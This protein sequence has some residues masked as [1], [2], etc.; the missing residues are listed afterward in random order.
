MRM[1]TL[2]A[3]LRFKG[4]KGELGNCFRLAVA[5]CLDCVP[6]RGGPEPELV[7]GTLRAGTPEEIA[8]DPNVSPVPFIHCWVEW[9]GA[10]LAP[11][12]LRKTGG[13]LMP[14]NP[15]AYYE[16]NGVRDTKRL[17][18]DS[19]VQMN[20]RLMILQGMRFDLTARL[21]ALAGIDWK[22]CPQRGGVV[23]A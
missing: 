13:K 21:L 17:S 11:T 10:I 20:V 22:T 1:P 12:T 2:E 14:I 18:R 23:P 7:I 5:L 4:A 9:E 15:A 3:A 6:D 16:M 8:E 19:I